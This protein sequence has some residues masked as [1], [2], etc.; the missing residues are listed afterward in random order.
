VGQSIALES[1]GVRR[2]LGRLCVHG[3]E[4]D[5]GG[6]VV[7]AAVQS[8]EEA[9]SGLVETQPSVAAVRGGIGRHRGAVDRELPIRHAPTIVDDY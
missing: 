1:I 2:E 7:G 3:L 6:E 4:L 9:R 5:G 8:D